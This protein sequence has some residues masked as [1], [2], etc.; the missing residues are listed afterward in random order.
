MED[1][2][3]SRSRLVSLDIGHNEPEALPDAT[4][5]TGEG[6]R[7]VRDSLGVPDWQQVLF[8]ELQDGVQPHPEAEG[9]SWDV[10]LEECSTQAVTHGCSNP[11]SD[12]SSDRAYLSK[13]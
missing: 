11:A 9:L 2:K 5:H 6:L 7:R 10:L 3:A 13:L 8:N 1:T 4:S 12:G